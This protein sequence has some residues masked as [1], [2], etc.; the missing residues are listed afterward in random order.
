MSYVII[1]ATGHIGNNIVRKLVEQQRDVKVITRKIDKSIADLPITYLVGNV[2]DKAFLEE[3]INPEDVVM[4]F[5]GIIDI[6][7][8]QKAATFDINYLGTIKV[9]DVCLEKKVKKYIYCSSV[10]AIYKHTADEVI[11]EPIRMEIDKFTQNYPKSKA[12]ATQYVMDIM[13]ANPEFNVAIIYPSAVIGINDWKP[14][15]V[16]KVVQ[17]CLKG[18]VEFGIKGGY[19]FVDVEDLA[20][21]TIR[22]S[23][24]NMR[25]NYILS[26]HNVTVFELYEAINKTIGK[27]RFIWHI[28]MFIVHMAIPFVPYLSHFMLGVILENHNYDSSKAQNELDFKLTPFDETIKKTVEW[29]TNNNLPTKKRK[30]K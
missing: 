30:N 21:A 16:G 25:G 20:D 1:G 12:L 11:S 19:N 24:N 27:K 28:P 4:H 5:A 6:K 13:A 22:L 8:K 17:D 7:N 15:Y 3:C 10:D 23:D 26:G 29:F 2:F 18:K 9:T 14:S